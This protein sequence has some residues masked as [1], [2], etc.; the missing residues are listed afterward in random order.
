[1]FWETRREFWVVLW[2]VGLD[3]PCR[4]FP[5]RDILRSEIQRQ[6]YI[7]PS[8]RSALFTSLLLKHCMYRHELPLCQNLSVYFPTY[9]KGMDLFL[10]LHK[11]SNAYHPLH[12]LHWFSI[13]YQK[14]KAAKNTAYWQA[15]SCWA[16]PK[17]VLRSAVHTSAPPLTP[18]SGAAANTEGGFCPP[19]HSQEAQ[20]STG[21]FQ[22]EVMDS[23]SC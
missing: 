11:L 15:V 13:H 16:V 14:R 1:M 23:K 4:S 6:I 9:L 12:S 5:A 19:S 21:P 7:C 22:T 20:H 8:L 17:A 2:G 3:D 10:P 18:V